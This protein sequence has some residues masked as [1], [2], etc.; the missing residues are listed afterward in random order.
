M[1]QIYPGILIVLCESY[2]QAARLF[3]DQQSRVLPARG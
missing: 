3:P 1:V 2:A